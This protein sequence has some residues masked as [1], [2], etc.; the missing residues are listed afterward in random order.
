MPAISEENVVYLLYKKPIKAT[1]MILII[2]KLSIL[3]C[4]GEIKFPTFH[5]KLEIIFRHTS[6]TYDSAYVKHR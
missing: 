6:S 2:R 1:A 4:Y 3:D 5:G